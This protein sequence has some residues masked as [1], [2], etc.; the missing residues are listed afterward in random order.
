VALGAHST[1]LSGS[2]VLLRSAVVSRLPGFA[3]WLL[4]AI[5]SGTGRRPGTETL[6]PSWSGRLAEDTV[7]F[8]FPLTSAQMAGGNGDPGWYFCFEQSPMRPRFG[9]DETPVT[10]MTSWADLD[11]SQVETAD[12]W[13]HLTPAPPVPPNAGGLSWGG[14]S[15]QM[16]AI[17][18][19]RPIRFAIHCSQLV[20]QSGAP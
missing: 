13:L 11:W 8:G 18:L 16:A 5:P 12:G 1:H 20:S 4:R 7:Y 19:Q 15:A 17:L 6:Q 3:P 2:V 10:T 14:D 9:L